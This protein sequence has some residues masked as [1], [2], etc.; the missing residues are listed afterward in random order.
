MTP[1]LLLIDLQHDYL[2]RP[3]LEP[4]GPELVARC[5]R[6]L[7]DFR[8]EGWPVVHCHTLIRPDGANRMP[9]WKRDNFWACIEGTSGAE[10][11]DPVAPRPDE[12]VVGKSYYS[13]FESDDLDAVLRACAVDVLVI[14]GLYVH[15]CVTATAL[16]AYQRGY[17]VF[18]ARDAV[19]ATHEGQRAAATEFLDGR[20]AR[21]L[22]AKEIVHRLSSP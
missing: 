19:A 11:P 1:G 22:D 2:A 4:D 21:L 6:L 10:T 16:D 9:H 14:A 3:A 20:A 8:H 12:P 5:G 17:E 13:A 15:A 7:E 18:I